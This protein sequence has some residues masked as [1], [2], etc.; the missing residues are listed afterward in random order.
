[1]AARQALQK[2][3]GA[4]K[5]PSAVYA[6]ALLGQLSF[7]TGEYDDAIRWWSAVDPKA[8]AGWGLDEPLRQ[9]VLLAGLLAFQRGR[10]ELAADRFREAGKLGLRD[11]RLGG[12]VTLSL[13]RAGQRLLYGGGQERGGADAPLGRARGRPGPRG[14][15]GALRGGRAGAGARRAGRLPRPE[16]A[17]HAGVG[18]QAPGQ[19]QGGPGRAAQDPAPRRQRRP[20]NGAAV[21][22]R[23]ELGPGRGRVQ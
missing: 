3:A 21:A 1:P 13:V 20:A 12:L 8:R 19:H 14:A 16:R 22:R 17:L 18:A 10:Y 9:T 2:V 15:A 4:D 11:R 7:H 23:R 5:S 6:R